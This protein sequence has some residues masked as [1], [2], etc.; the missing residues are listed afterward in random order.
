MGQNCTFQFPCHHH[1][2]MLPL[3]VLVLGCYIP[4]FWCV[5]RH[6]RM[7]LYQYTQTRPPRIP[8]LHEQDHLQIKNANG[9]EIHLIWESLVTFSS[10][11]YSDFC[12]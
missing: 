7:L 6:H 12:D 3:R 11:V 1:Y 4:D 2:H 10:L 8:T 9:M 5:I